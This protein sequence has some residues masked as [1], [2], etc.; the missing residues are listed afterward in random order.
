MFPFRMK[1]WDR[2]NLSTVK[3]TRAAVGVEGEQTV[4]AQEES[5]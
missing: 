5:F 2:Q 4:K 1:F 3:E